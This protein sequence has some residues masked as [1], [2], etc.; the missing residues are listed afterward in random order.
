MDKLL[1]IEEAGQVT[2]LSP[3]TIRALIRQGKLARVKIGRRVLV[4]TSAV[5]DFIEA[6]KKVDRIRADSRMGR[7]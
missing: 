3:W 7:D 6:C 4:E 2:G 5:R 1:S